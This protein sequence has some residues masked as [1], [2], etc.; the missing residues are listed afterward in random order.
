MSFRYDIVRACVCVCV[1]MCVSAPACHSP[2][3]A[4][5]ATIAKR[6]DDDF[7]CNADLC[8]YHVLYFGRQGRDHLP[9]H[10]DEVHEAWANNRICHR[11]PKAPTTA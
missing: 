7:A 11:V 3:P 1:Y 4:E 9:L 10:G 2:V 6:R 8:D 5:D